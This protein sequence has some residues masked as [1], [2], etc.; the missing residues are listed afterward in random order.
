MALK[1]EKGAT[2]RNTDGLQKLEKARKQIPPLSL[3]KEHSPADTLNPVK[4]SWDLKPP[5][6][7]GNKSVLLRH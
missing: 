6:Q 7:P 5:E 4:P 1:M 2:Q 3:Q